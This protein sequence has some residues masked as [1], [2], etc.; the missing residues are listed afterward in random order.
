M[1]L[2]NPGELVARMELGTPERILLVDV[3]DELVRLFEGARGNRRTTLSTGG[4]AIRALK[5]PFD[6]VLVWRE[7]RG[8]SRAVFDGAL[9]RLESGAPLWIV[10]ALKKVRG[11]STPAVH[12]LELP[13][14]VK[15]FEK[16]GLAHDREVRVSAWHVAHRFARKMNNEPGSGGITPRRGRTSP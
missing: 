7:H 8:G 2:K 11:P 4:E 6:A 1:N 12:R 3:P 5:H 13:D 10:T 16:E 14:L 9:K 15:A